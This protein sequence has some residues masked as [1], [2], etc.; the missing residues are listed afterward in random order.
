MHRYSTSDSKLL[1]CLYKCCLCIVC[2]GCVKCCLVS[3]SSF[4][5]SESMLNPLTRTLLTSFF[6]I[7]LCIYRTESLKCHFRC[8]YGKHVFSRSDLHRSRLIF[9]RLHSGLRA[10]TVSRS[11][12]T[13]GTDL[14][15]ETLSTKPVSWKCPSVGLPH[16]RP[17]SSSQSFY[18]LLLLLNTLRRNSL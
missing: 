17:V 11:A 5:S 1:Q 15:R 13:D 18:L 10:K 12:D 8:R 6:F 14:W 3:N 7:R 2:G 9:C 4:V 16:A